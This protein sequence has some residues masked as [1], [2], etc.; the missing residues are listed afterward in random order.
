MCYFLINILKIV[1]MSARCSVIIHQTSAFVI[2]WLK[3][4]FIIQ[5]F[6]LVGMQG[7]ILYPG[8]GYPR[9]NTDTHTLVFWF[10]KGV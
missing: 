8:A 3:L 2:L 10:M 5:Q 1:A 7:L 6:L 4:H 9:Y